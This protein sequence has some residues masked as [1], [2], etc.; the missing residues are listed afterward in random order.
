[1]QNT[2]LHFNVP[3]IKVECDSSFS[4]YSISTCDKN[5]VINLEF[6]CFVSHNHRLS[7]VADAKT[8]V[9]NFFFFVTDKIWVKRNKNDYRVKLCVGATRCMCDK[10]WKIA[11]GNRSVGRFSFLFFFR[12]IQSKIYDVIN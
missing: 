12:Q 10:V 5:F 3:D 7:R 6:F 9:R 4:L 1:M 8:F 2:D 11:A